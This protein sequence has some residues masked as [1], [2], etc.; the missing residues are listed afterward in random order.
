M[1]N[2]LDLLLDISIYYPE[3]YELV[4]KYT[5]FLNEYKN[6]FED[7]DLSILYYDRE[8]LSKKGWVDLD[9]NY[10]QKF[11]YKGYQF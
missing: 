3:Y 9:D 8:K 10:I 4:L 2:D 7:S 5:K 1:L 6:T 11:N